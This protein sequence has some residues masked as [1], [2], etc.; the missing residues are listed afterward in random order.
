MKAQPGPMV[1]GNHFF[2]NAPLLWVKWIPAGAVTSR[3]WI[4]AWAARTRQKAINHGDAEVRRNFDHEISLCDRGSVVNSFLDGIYR[5]AP[6]APL[7]SLRGTAEA[8]VPTC[9]VVTR[10][11]TDSCS[12]IDCRSLLP[13]GC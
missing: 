13:S 5:E 7:A 1:S 4:W 9:V 3:N 11:G 8:A 2:P 12:G 10:S 6:G